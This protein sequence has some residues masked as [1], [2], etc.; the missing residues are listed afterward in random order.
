MVDGL[1]ADNDDG[2]EG[3]MSSFLGQFELVS[4]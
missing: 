4:K 1:V 3:G 2:I